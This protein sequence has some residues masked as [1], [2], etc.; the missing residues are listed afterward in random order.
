MF[1]VH[2]KKFDDSPEDSPGSSTSTTSTMSVFSMQSSRSK[3]SRHRSKPS[4]ML[5]TI[6]LQPEV[7]EEDEDGDNWLAH[8]CTPLPRLPLVA[9]PRKPR[10]G[11]ITL[12][13]PRS[14]RPSRALR[15]LADELP[16]P[17]L[18][19]PPPPFSPLPPFPQ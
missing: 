6:V 1:K 5:L 14:V 15:P 2:V 17:S 16:S 11:Q 7:Q 9:R 3:S 13:S 19:S 8:S 12:P 10:S 4:V 18:P